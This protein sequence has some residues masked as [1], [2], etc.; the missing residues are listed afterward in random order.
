MRKLTFI[1]VSAALLIGFGL[2]AKAQSVVSQGS[3]GT[4]LTY[5]LMSDSTFTIYGSGAMTSNPWYSSHRNRIKTVVVGDSVTNIGNSAFYGCTKLRSVIIGNSVTTIGLQAFQ[6]CSSLTSVTIPNSVITI[7][8]LAFQ[9]CS[10]LTSVTIPNSVTTIGQS[11][12]QYCSSLTSVTIPNSVT[13]IGQSAFQY[14]SSLTSV[15]IGNSVDN[16]APQ[17]FYDCR[18]L[19]S[20]TIGNSVKSIGQ[21]VFQ[22]CSSLTSV[23]IPNSV[24]S[25]GQ[26]AFQFCSSLTSINVDNNNS[27]YSSIDGIVYNKAQDILIL[28]PQGKTGTIVIPNSVTSIGNEAFSYCFNLSSVIIGN[29]VTS[30][31]HNVFHNCSQLYIVSLN[32]NP[33]IIGNAFSRTSIEEG[34]S[35]QIYVRVYVWDSLR[36]KISNWSSQNIRRIIVT[37]TAENITYKSA[38]FKG[39][40]LFGND[41]VIRRGFLLRQ[42]AGQVDTLITNNDSVFTYQTTNLLPGTT[43]FVRAFCELADGLGV[44]NETSFFTIPFKQSGTAFLVE[45]QADLI[46]LANLVNGG[47]S[48]ENQEFILSNDITLPNTPNN[49]LSIGNRETYRPF[50]GIFNGN[51][52]H[53]YNVYIDHPN[54]PYQGF[55]GYTQNAHIKELGLVN[56]TASGREYTGGM[57]AY[58]ENTRLDYSYV[59]GGTLFALSY[60]GGLVGYQTQ[61]T[62]SIITGCYNTCTV[63]GNNYVGGLLG[64]SNQGTVRNSY[65]AALVTGQGK[66]VGAI[67]GGAQDVLFYNWAFNDSITGQKFAIG[68]NKFK[69]GAEGDMTS[70]E[71]RMQSFVNTLNQGLVT[72]MWK[73]DY[74]KPINNGFPIL[75]WQK[76]E[77]VGIV[78]AN[79]IRPEIRVYPNPA[80]YELRITNYETGFGA[81]QLKEGEVVEIYSV[82]GQLVQTSPNP[83]KGG[84]LAPSLLERAGGEVTI[85]ISH[86]AKGM[87]FLKIGNQI[88]KFIKE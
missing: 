85:D 1:F 32:I 39:R 26:S 17:V 13:T 20:V 55:F 88:T 48:F 40:V 31:G 2:S 51:N 11:A 87:Y 60:C 75:M 18:S 44:G 8:Q 62:N 7:G 9:S 35:T 78:G 80:N 65:V 61:G 14:C 76:G 50:S 53:I 84:E 15:I 3:C 38:S 79:A 71:M 27:E 63:S 22:S 56:I 41:A 74:N 24:T 68:E 43:Y 64:Y 73:M 72:P 49:I 46:R 70:S 69:A 52:K 33:P 19:T 30:I 5:V 57:V 10:S 67:I 83:S 47:N 28:C 59:S 42:E 45:N 12:F 6:S 81:S 86:L 23:T 82:V 66:G 4:N 16:I 37:D 25:I 77:D 58:A 29:S 36:Y 54:T 21:S 34:G